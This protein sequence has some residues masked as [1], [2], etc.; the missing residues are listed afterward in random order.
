[1]DSGTDYRIYDIPEEEG[2]SESAERYREGTRKKKLTILG[3]AV[4][5]IV[6]AAASLIMGNSD[7]SAL[8]VLAAFFTHDTQSLIGKYV[9]NIDLPIMV[10]AAVVGAGL[11]LA[12][13]IMQCILKNPLASPYTLGLSSAAAF[14]AAFSIMYLNSGAVFSS[15]ILGEV[16]TPLCAFASSM[17]ATGIIIALVKLTRV[18]TETVILAG[19]AVSSIFSAGLTL[20]QYLS[21]P[22]MMSEIV[23]WTFGSVTD[24]DWRWDLIMLSVLL[25]IAVYYMAERWTLNALNAGDEVARG[26]GVN[27]DRFM[28]VGLILASLLSAVMLSKFGIIAFVGLLGPHMAR[29][30]IGDDHRFLIPASLLIGALLMII[31]DGVAL[32]IVRPMVLPVGLLTSLLGGPAFIY[33]LI[34]RYRSRY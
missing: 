33:L 2:M 6:C 18:S 30:L 10:A 32:N 24:A 5:I 8:D 16:C 17:I 13:V 3:L 29:M 12:G 1:M 22:V 21:D 4:C 9:W 11:A 28:V 34:R 20:M 26:L 15:G 25:C 31:A 7:M 19:I 14:G 27:T 23:S